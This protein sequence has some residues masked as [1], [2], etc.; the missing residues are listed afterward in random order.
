MRERKRGER[1]K[2]GKEIY[3]EKEGREGSTKYHDE[4]SWCVYEISKNREA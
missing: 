2:E 4:V 1:Y 3:R